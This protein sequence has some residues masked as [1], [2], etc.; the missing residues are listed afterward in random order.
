MHART[1]A[2]IRA[3]THAREH[4]QTPPEVLNPDH[5]FSGSTDEELELL[6]RSARRR[7]LFG[8]QIRPRHCPSSRVIPGGGS[9]QEMTPNNS[10]LFCC[11]SAAE[12][13]STIYQ[14]LPIQ[15]VSNPVSRIINM[16]KVM[17]IINPRNRYHGPLDNVC[18][19]L[20]PTCARECFASNHDER[21][22]AP[23][24]GYFWAQ[25][26]VRFPKKVAS[27][28]SSLQ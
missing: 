2:R 25:L 21:F 10:F 16:L 5:I 27:Q 3:S 11:L 14:P 23:I 15:I 17:A 1:H 19:K 22:R 20:H 8:P 28:H 7:N 26:R 18:P 12:L 13:Q 9:G 6:A 4:A 24:R